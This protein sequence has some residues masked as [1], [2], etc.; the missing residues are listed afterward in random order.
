MEVKLNKQLDKKVYLEFYDLRAEGVDFGGKIKKDQPGIT[1]KN[2]PE[3][4]DQFYKNNAKILKESLDELN[5]CLIDNADSFFIELEK[6]FGINFSQNSYMGY[7]SIF[8]CN[9]RFVEN[10][11]FQVF[12]KK[13]LLGKLEVV[14]HEIM[15]FAFFDYCDQFIKE[16][17]GLDKNDGPLWKLSEIFN[18]IM[19]NEPQ[20]QKI[21]KRPEQLFYPDLKS[22][23]EYIEIVWD[24]TEKNIN[25][26]IKESLKYLNSTA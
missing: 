7:L 24:K 18:I 17:R 13:D 9:P 26:F 12:Y 19:L 22:D 23:L 15:H 25:I 2:Y 8:D 14:L 1:I 6:T 16:T 21:L 5:S 4:I 3:Y 10:Q 11:T 20:Y